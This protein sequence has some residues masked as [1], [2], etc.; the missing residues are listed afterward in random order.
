MVAL[1]GGAQSPGPYVRPCKDL[2]E[3]GIEP[4]RDLARP[5]WTLLDRDANN[6]WQQPALQGI[7]K[8][9]DFDLTVLISDDPDTIRRWIEQVSPMLRPET[10]VIV[11]SAQAEPLVRPYF[12]AEQSPIAAFVPGLIGGAGYEGYLLR[13]GP[14]RAAWD[15]FGLGSLMGIVLILGAGTYNLYILWKEREAE[16]RGRR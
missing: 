12:D 10:F 3:Q 11:S 4:V 7:E 15:A 9:N 13:E 5:I 2:T 14:G 8:L 16:R 6:P 1:D